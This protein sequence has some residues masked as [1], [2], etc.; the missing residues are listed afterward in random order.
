MFSFLRRAKPAMDA[1]EPALTSTRMIS[2]DPGRIVRG[3][4]FHLLDEGKARL[5]ECSESVVYNLSLRM[6]HLTISADRWA[7]M[8]NAQR[9]Q[10]LLDHSHIV[11]TSA[12]SGSA[13]LS[14]RG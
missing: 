11:V 13:T 2:F 9:L 4:T 5:V 14:V 6:D 7:A 1:T 12:L 3:I 8:G 10:W